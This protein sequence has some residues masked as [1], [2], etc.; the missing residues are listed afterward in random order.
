MTEIKFVI[1]DPKTGKSYSKN[2]DTDLSGMKIGDKFP[3]QYLGLADFEFQI[4]GGSDNAGFPMRFDIPTQN[5]KSAFLGSGPGVRIKRKGVKLRKTVRGSVIGNSTSQVNIKI[6][7]QDKQTIE[8]ALG[9]EPKE[10]KKPELK[11]GQEDK[12]EEIAKQIAES[13]KEEKVT[14]V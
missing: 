10:E 9:I 6:V 3:G 12:K 1:N 7:K 4:T 5:R 11:D 13:K 2:H 8:K 14:P